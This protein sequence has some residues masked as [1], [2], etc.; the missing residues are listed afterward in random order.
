MDGT[1]DDGKR[2]NDLFRNNRVITK[3]TVLLIA[4]IFRKH[5]AHSNVKKIKPSGSQI[6]PQLLRLIQK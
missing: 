2:G 3:M 1:H 5:N 6:T 4:K